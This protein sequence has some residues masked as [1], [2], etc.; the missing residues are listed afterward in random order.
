M[1]QYKLVIDTETVKLNNDNPAL[2]GNSLPYDIAAIV[3]DVKG[4]IY[5]ARSM[6]IKEIY[7]DAERMSTAY[8]SDK[9]PLYEQ[10]LA[11]YDTELVSFEA[12]RNEILNLIR[13]YSIKEVYMHNSSFDYS[14]LN[15]MTQLCLGTDYFFPLGM[16]DICDSMLCAQ[17][18]LAQMPTYR[19]WCEANGYMTKHKNPR[20][21][22]NVETIQRFLTKDD[23]FSEQHIALED[24]YDEL[25]IIVYCYRQHKKMKKVRYKGGYPKDLGQMSWF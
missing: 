25:D 14:A 4:R 9:L 19:R 17:S 7:N 21:R 11:T 12:A 3:F 24:C 18:V 1:P 23:R 15:L 6:V 8:F 2:I 13:A 22:V 5:T 16:V 10:S 20:P